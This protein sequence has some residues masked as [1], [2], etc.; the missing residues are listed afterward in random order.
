MKYQENYTKHTAPDLKTSGCHCRDFLPWSKSSVCLIS[1]AM[2]IYPKE[3]LAKMAYLSRRQHI[4]RKLVHR[5]T[6]LPATLFWMAFTP[7]TSRVCSK[8]DQCMRFPR[9]QD[10][11]VLQYS[12]VGQTDTFSWGMEIFN[13][14]LSFLSPN[15]MIL[16][17]GGGLHVVW[18]GELLCV[19]RWSS[20][21]KTNKCINWT[22]RRDEEILVLSKAQMELTGQPITFI[23]EDVFHE[24]R[25]LLVKCMWASF[26]SSISFTHSLNSSSS[27]CS[28][29]A[30][31]DD[32]FLS[33]IT[34]THT[35]T[36]KYNKK[37]ALW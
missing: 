18:G 11:A 36:N 17:A 25:F 8:D 13:F 29:S 1:K 34:I 15:G 6:L 16:S 33:A 22:V 4:E 35:H 14:Q 12:A 3:F 37:S 31:S 21:S 10:Q 20:M 24:W 23:F 27:W 7:S 26:L 9:P 19:S 2:M 5:H 30:C 28:R 32:F